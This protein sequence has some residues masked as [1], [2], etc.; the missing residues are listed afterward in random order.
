[1]ASSEAVMRVR[2]PITSSASASRFGGMVRPRIGGLEVDHHL[3][4]DGLLHRQIG[5]I[6]ALEDAIDVACY[7]APLVGQAGK[8]SDHRQ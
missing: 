4:L 6:L 8:T 5:G 1:V 3:E 7:A 2:Y